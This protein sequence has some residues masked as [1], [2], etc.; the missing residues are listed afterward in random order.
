MEDLQKAQDDSMHQLYRETQKEPRNWRIISQLN[1]DIRENVK[2]LSELGLG[3]PV[4]AAI[5]SKLEM[6]RAVQR[7][8]NNR[9]DVRSD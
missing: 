4:I 7:D 6:A 2:L 3:T 1:Y 9:C 5:R 8:N